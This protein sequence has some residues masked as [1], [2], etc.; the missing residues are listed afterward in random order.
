LRVVCYFEW[1]VYFCVMSYCSTTATG[2]KTHLRFKKI[3]NNN[4][5]LRT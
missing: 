4:I 2:H 3:N 1:H 5:L